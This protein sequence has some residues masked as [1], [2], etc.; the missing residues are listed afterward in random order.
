LKD[1][2]TRFP[3]SQPSTFCVLLLFVKKFL[4]KI[5]RSGVEAGQGVASHLA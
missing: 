4:K 2:F 5:V 1:D 3:N